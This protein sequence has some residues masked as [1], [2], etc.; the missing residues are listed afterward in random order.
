MPCSHAS[1]SGV[2]VVELLVSAK[3]IYLSP[4]VL[5]EDDMSQ[6]YVDQCVIIHAYLHVFDLTIEQTKADCNG[7]LESTL[8]RQSYRVGARTSAAAAGK[9][10]ATVQGPEPVL[11][12]SR[13]RAPPPNRWPPPRSA[14]DS[15]MRRPTPPRCG[16]ASS[17]S[18]SPAAA[19]PSLAPGGSG[20]ATAGVA[21]SSAKKA[22]RAR[23]LADASA[24][25][26][27]GAGRGLRASCGRG[28]HHRCR[29]EVVGGR[30]WSGSPGPSAARGRATGSE[31]LSASSP[32]ASPNS[33]GESRILA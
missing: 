14:R 16:P 21:T 28:L 33:S 20:E 8:D 6:Y 23:Q 30:H 4:L 32:N 11:E 2:I 7:L 9:A 27:D 17:V 19:V 3:T 29:E 18:T 1:R 15:P 5:D 13:P 26:W 31:Q 22:R 24:W 25:L 12:I 10:A